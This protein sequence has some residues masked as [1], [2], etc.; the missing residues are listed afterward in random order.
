MPKQTDTNDITTE[1][2][3]DEFVESQDTLKEVQHGKEKKH[4][5][6]YIKAGNYIFMSLNIILFFIIIV[7]YFYSYS[8]EKTDKTEIG[9]LKPVCSFMLGNV[10]KS[11]DPCYSVTSVL[12]EYT[13]KLSA[14]EEKIAKK[15]I[16]I[17][18]ELY[19]IIN[20]NYSNKVIF[21][22]DKSNSR[23]KP[24]TI[25]QDFDKIKKEF[26]SSFERS[27]VDCSNII[28]SEDN[29]M[30]LDC[31]I[32]SS[33]WDTSIIDINDGVRSILPGWGTSIS[34]ASSFIN[35]IENHNTKRFSV[36]VKPEQL[37]ST[38]TLDEGPYTQVTS[39]SLELQYI[40]PE[41]L[42]F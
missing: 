7:L 5:Y 10:Y 38:A 19:G 33:D 17:M 20:F 13:S 6:D 27:N 11:G 9:F 14:S 3:F 8:Q 22:V 15:M 16:S 12:N 42:S 36:I 41:Y 2:I 4:I 34:R 28:I 40:N 23:L 29:I 26:T 18:S 1:N 37:V 24:L 25:L 30:S 35:F 32:F 31:D 21:L 39:I